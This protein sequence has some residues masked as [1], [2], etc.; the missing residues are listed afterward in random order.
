LVSTISRV[1]TKKNNL[2]ILGCW[3]AWERQLEGITSHVS[4][5]ELVTRFLHSLQQLAHLII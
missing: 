4:G 5:Q 1:K 2:Q 3:L